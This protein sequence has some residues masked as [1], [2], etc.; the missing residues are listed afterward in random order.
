M[1]VRAM[2]AKGASK[3]AGVEM[4]SREVLR[5][6][7]AEL[8]AIM[9]RSDDDMRFLISE[10]L[11]DALAQSHAMDSDSL[12]RLPPMH[13]W[14]KQKPMRHGDPQTSDGK[15]EKKFNKD[16]SHFAHLLRSKTAATATL[17]S[18][19][20]CSVG[21]SATENRYQPPGEETSVPMLSGSDDASS[22]LDG[23]ST[24]Q[25]CSAWL[26]ALVHSVIFEKLMVALVLANALLIGVQTYYVRPDISEVEDLEIFRGLELLQTCFCGIYALELILRLC[27]DGC[28][29][30]HAQG[31]QLNIFDSVIICL[32]VLDEAIR[33]AAGHVISY[34]R[35]DVL[36]LL[37]LLRIAR[38]LRLVRL[39]DEFQ[40][41]VT[42]IMTSLTSLLWVFI[43]MI[44]LIFFFSVYFTQ[45]SLEMA[46]PD[47]PQYQ[48]LMLRFGSIHRSALTLFE[49]TFNGLSWDEGA[50]L[51]INCVSPASCVV[52]C[53][54]NIFCIVALMNLMTGVFVDKALKAAQEEEEL[55]LCNQVTSLFFDVDSEHSVDWP[56]FQSKISEPGML[57][58]F[59]AIDINPAEAVNLFDLLDTMYL[60]I[61]TTLVFIRGCVGDVALR[62]CKLSRPP[63]GHPRPEAGSVAEA[64]LQ[65][66]WPTSAIDSSAAC[67]SASA[68][69]I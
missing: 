54:Y 27:A 35:Y 25:R 46:S 50:Q 19:R 2:T 57:D 4:V 11:G 10:A 61:Y 69:M 9:H 5:E 37:R 67:A 6:E 33:S 43:L 55:H 62:T 23:P 3:E 60:G 40:R 20:A 58:Y 28:G 12:P 34:S 15:D 56:M 66:Q 64:D 41:I 47:H 14:V 31:W 8:K 36:R 38:L 39:A 63:C 65:L 7:L 18:A 16:S 1:L 22:T 21:V 44:L 51:L 45:V 29:Y 32:T 48:Q 53:F 52:L 26:Q 24:L 49:S 68:G 42:S 13:S 59:R 30:F 17:G